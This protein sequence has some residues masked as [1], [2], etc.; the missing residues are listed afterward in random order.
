MN[1]RE[2]LYSSHKH[3]IPQDPSP[4]PSQLS[5]NR[6]QSKYKLKLLNDYIREVNKTPGKSKPMTH[7]VPWGADQRIF[8]ELEQRKRQKEFREMREQRRKGREKAIEQGRARIGLDL[9]PELYQP[10]NQSNYHNKEKIRTT[11]KQTHPPKTPNK[12]IVNYMIMKR[13]RDQSS[14][15]LKKLEEEMK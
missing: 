6:T 9:I 7:K 15:R 10:I 5:S 11:E 3:P 12:E 8:N 13:K 14:E 2:L 1:I 4:A